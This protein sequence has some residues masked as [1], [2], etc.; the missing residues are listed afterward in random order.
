MGGHVAALVGT[1]ADQHLQVGSA[2]IPHDDV[3]VLD[4]V[5]AGEV[6]DC[7]GG[8]RVDNALPVGK[9][10][11]ALAILTLQLDTGPDAEHRGLSRV[12][13]DPSGFTV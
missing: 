1:R 10:A 8:P 6:P 12:K 3:G 9:E 7:P 11:C 2:R 5:P 4:P 13:S